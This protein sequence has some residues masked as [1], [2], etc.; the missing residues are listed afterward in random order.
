M[1]QTREEIKPSA[2]LKAQ[3]SLKMFS[4]KVKREQGSCREDSITKKLLNLPHSP[5]LGFSIAVYAIIL[6]VAQ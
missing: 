5:L 4:R 2:L 1:S 3:S 6:S